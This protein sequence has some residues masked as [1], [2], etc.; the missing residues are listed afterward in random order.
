MPTTLIS[1]LTLNIPSERLRPH[2]RGELL[3]SRALHVA[4]EA[5]DHPSRPSNR[6]WRNPAPAGEETPRKP[7]ASVRKCGTRRWLDP[8][9]GSTR[10]DGPGTADYRRRR[11]WARYRGCTQV[12]RL[13][14]KHGDLVRF[15]PQD[16]RPTTAH[17]PALI[18]ADA[19]GL[20]GREIQQRITPPLASTVSFSIRTIAVT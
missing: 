5:A 2:H 11:Q 14:V 17:R 20:F 16:Q 18:H 9:S 12:H 7:A 13:T 4:P 8:A 1:P 6:K 19:A 15:Q 3:P 10:P